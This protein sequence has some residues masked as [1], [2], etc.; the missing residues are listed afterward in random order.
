MVKGVTA[1][2]RVE[3]GVT[4]IAL[5]SDHLIKHNAV[6]SGVG[7]LSLQ[8]TGGKGAT[9][10]GLYFSIAQPQQANFEETLGDDGS[11]VLTV[12]L[13]QFWPAAGLLHAGSLKAHYRTS[14]GGYSGHLGVFQAPTVHVSAPFG[15]DIWISLLRA[16]WSPLRLEIGKPELT[17]AHGDGAAS[18]ALH[19]S[20]DAG[21][22]GDLNV[23]GT[24]FKKVTAAMTRT[25]G[26][27][28][29]EE[30]LGEVDGAGTQ[31]FEWKPIARSFD[32]L[33]VGRNPGL[34]GGLL[35]S[36]VPW[37]E[38]TEM[39]NGLGTQFWGKEDFVLC[40]SPALRYTI[41][42]R[43]DRGMLKHDEDSTNLTLA[44]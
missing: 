34:T 19:P 43:G 29:L 33:F 32:L 21:F 12:R 42:L 38:A 41:S 11:Q 18:L 3:N 23:V 6:E 1:D 4:I 30:V 44:W 36:S 8:F 16:P 35:P 24:A 13:D 17:L 22:S 37:D 5:R 2:Y 27:V 9:K 39:T 15:G 40:D 31:T 10:Q 14:V 28:A 26:S 25:L 7:I 20:G